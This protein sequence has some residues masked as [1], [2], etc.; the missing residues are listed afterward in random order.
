MRQADD[1]A[2]IAPEPSPDKDAAVAAYRRYGGTVDGE[3]IRLDL[4]ARGLWRSSRP[5]HRLLHPT[6]LE[7]N[8]VTAWWGGGSSRPRSDRDE[9]YY[10]GGYGDET[11]ALR[12][13]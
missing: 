5:G 4:M 12:P 10:Y 2:P 9:Y 6:A 8:P 7:R 3:V 11:T 1:A 13:L